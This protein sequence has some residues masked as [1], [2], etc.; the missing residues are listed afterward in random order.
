MFSVLAV[1]WTLPTQAEIKITREQ[2]EAIDAIFARFNRPDSPGYAVGIIQDGKLILAR[3]YGQANL[4]YPSPITAKTSFHLASLSKQFT[5]AAVALLI[6]E[7]K[8][9]LETPVADY[10][11]AAAHF[12]A[13]L[14]L[15]HLIYFTSGLPEYTSLP[16]ASGLPWFSDFYFTIDEAIATTLRAPALRFSPGERW[17]YANVNYMLLAKI[18]ERVSGLSLAD[19]LERRFFAPL[20]MTHTSLN[21]DTTLVIPQRAIGYTDRADP[22]VQQQL[23]GIG[24]SFRPGPGYAQMLRVSPHYGGSGI[25]STLEDFARWDEN[26]YHPTV[27]G[28]VFVKQ[29]L[30]RQRFAHDKD[31]DAFGLVYGQFEGREMLW[32]SGS[33]LDTSTY[34][35]RFPADHLTVVCLSN[36]AFGKAEEKARLVMSIIFGSVPAIPRP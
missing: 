7:G 10:F 3:G 17:E 25:F 12:G 29:M 4:D 18:V 23:A 28:P 6:Q 26:F 27:G 34:F 2:S 19:F 30:L 33:D 31:N 21:D 35:A 15:K 32:F 24:I 9:S 14:R 1:I 8:L 11:P 16:R 20:G 22:Y 36:L 13:D 5:A